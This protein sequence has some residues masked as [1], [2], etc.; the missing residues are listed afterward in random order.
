MKTKGFKQLISF[1]LILSIMFT[2]AMPAHA[3]FLD[4]LVSGFT[5]I[6]SGAIDTAT[7]YYNQG[8]ELYNQGKDY[9][10]QAMDY[11]KQGKEIYNEF[12]EFSK[13]PLGYVLSYL[14]GSSDEAAQDAVAKNS[15]NPKFY[16]VYLNG[17]TVKLGYKATLT[18]D[19]VK[20]NGVPKPNST[21]HK[22]NE[23]AYNYYVNGAKSKTGALGSGGCTAWFDPETITLYLQNYN[24]GSLGFFNVTELMGYDDDKEKDN[25]LKKGKPAIVE[26]PHIATLNIVLKGNNVINETVGAGKKDAVG[27]SHIGLVNIKAVDGGKLTINTTVASG[28][29]KDA[30]GILAASLT[31]SNSAD[32]TVNV[33]GPKV[34]NGVR[35]FSNQV[36]ESRIYISQSA[37]L[38]V[39]AK[40]IGSGSGSTVVGVQAERKIVF[41]NIST[42]DIAITCTA[43]G[44]AKTY[45]VKAPDGSEVIFMQSGLVTLK[46]DKDKGT[47]IFGGGKVILDE[48]KKIQVKDFSTSSP[49]YKEYRGAKISIAD[50]VTNVTI[51]D[52]PAPIQG[53]AGEA[54]DLVNWNMDYKDPATGISYN[55]RRE[56]FFEDGITR[57]ENARTEPGMDYLIRIRVQ[58]NGEGYGNHKGTNFV[59]TENVKITAK[60][61]TGE[62]LQE[63]T[64]ARNLWQPYQMEFYFKYKIPGTRKKLT[65]NYDPQKHDLKGGTVNQET[66]E[67]G[68]V[69]RW[70]DTAVSGGSG[71]YDFELVESEGRLPGWM[72]ADVGNNEMLISALDE[73]RMYDTGTWHILPNTPWAASKATIRAWDLVTGESVSFTINIGALT[74]PGSGMQFISNIAY[75]VPMGANGTQVD[76]IDLSGGV[77]GGSGDYLFTKVS[78]PDWLKISKD[79]KLSG[80]R[81]GIAPTTTAV[82]KALDTKNSKGA[83]RTIT[84]RV[85][86]VFY[87]DGI[88]ADT[89][90]ADTDTPPAS[91]DFPPSVTG[92]VDVDDT[93]WYAQGIKYVYEKKLMNGVGDGRFSPDGTLSRA[94]LVTIL[95]RNT[96]SPNMAGNPNQ[97]IDIDKG[98]WYTDA[99]IWGSTYGLINGVGEGRFNPDGAI[100]REQLAVILHRLELSEGFSLPEISPGKN[101]SD[102]SSISEY[103]KKA[104]LALA[105]QGVFRDLPADGNRINPQSGATRADV[106]VVLYRF[107]E[108]EQTAPVATEAPTTTPAPT[109]TPAPTPTTA[110]PT[111]TTAPTSTPPA[112][113]APT[114]TPPA[115]AS[116]LSFVKQSSFDIP[117]GSTYS[118]ISTVNV[119]SGASGGQTPYTFSKVSGPDWLKVSSAGLVSGSRQSTESATTAIIMVTDSKGTS[120]VITINVGQVGTPPTTTPPT[121]TTPP[122]SSSSI[123]FLKDAS[124]DIPSGS[125]Y[126][127]ISTINIGG[128]ASGGT[129]PYTYSKQSGP[130]WVKVSAAGLISGSRQSKA[131][132]TTAVI[133]VTDSTGATATITINVGEVK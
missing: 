132:A 23:E 58:V 36:V 90:P 26:K 85:G 14:N 41:Y 100:T 71:R 44:S 47:D 121:T 81:S 102:S 19:T 53:K 48:S 31:I 2:I 4:S 27:I 55:L 30:I 109:E 83:Y 95:Y 37:K 113:T 126:T 56:I 117:A 51:N 88:S 35:V 130:D 45:P 16:G 59:E 62:V 15:V 89:P 63:V 125:I 6:V 34:V 1:T 57:V 76:S 65:V 99:V 92:F 39:N 106:S 11:Y 46:W 116:P 68:V 94:M 105:A 87:V 5:D 60:L 118:G 111:T 43:E 74:D 28:T 123:T 127:G 64:E 18:T 82:I 50:P 78:G 79:G 32:V 96:G 107:L 72:E 131:P 8:K 110:P 12:G 13:D 21:Y 66:G 101:Y 115:D 108:A 54:Y 24:G 129:A 124:F 97:F 40:G 80:T 42:T 112:T 133:Q 25:V 93:K 86:R 7:G 49:S 70:V 120:A 9:Y 52:I 61:T 98:Q 114:P 3:G 119:S 29:D 10:D 122:A 104:V 67:E 17:G 22:I 69:Y 73:Y 91:Y 128:S 84:I 75:D 20:E 38:T 33:N 103:A 77:K